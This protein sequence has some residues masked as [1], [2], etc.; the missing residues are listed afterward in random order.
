MIQEIYSSSI[1]CDGIIKKNY[2]SKVEVDFATVHSA[3]ISIYV[4]ACRWMVSSLCCIG[5]SVFWVRLTCCEECIQAVPSPL[6]PGV[7]CNDIFLD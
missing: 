1:H 5:T 2:L 3:P 4:D 6:H 7:I